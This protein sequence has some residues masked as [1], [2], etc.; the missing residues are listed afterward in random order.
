[1]KKRKLFSLQM[2]T[3]EFRNTIGNPYVHIFGVGMP[4]LMLFVISRAVTAELNEPA[5]LSSVVTSLFLGIGAIIPMAT[6]LMGY[7]VSHAQEMEKGIPQRMELFGIPER[8]TLC[9]RAV[10]EGI[11]MLIAFGIYFAVAFLFMDVTKPTISGISLYMGC[12]LIL[13]IIL[14]CLAHAIATI[15]QKFGT[16]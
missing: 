14:F 7:G 4:I 11:F 1:M 12:I 10:S 13:S 6:V 2:L 9:N 5:I 3:F 16:T 8:I 15:L